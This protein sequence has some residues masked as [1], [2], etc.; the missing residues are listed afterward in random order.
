MSLNASYAPPDE[1]SA[2]IW[3][4]VSTLIGDSVLGFTAFGK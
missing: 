1:T 3:I 4:E 2:E